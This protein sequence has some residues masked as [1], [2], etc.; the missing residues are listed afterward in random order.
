MTQQETAEFVSSLRKTFAEVEALPMPSIACV[1]GFALGGGAEL[2]LACDMRILDAS[3][4]FGFPETRL[5]IIPGAG[6]TQR[7]PRIVGSSKAKE[8]ILTGEAQRT[9]QAACC[10]NASLSPHM[11]AGSMLSFR[12]IYRCLLSRSAPEMWL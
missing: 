6:G 9:K 1:E 8:L 3:A 5:G 11:V 4:V 12:A 7:L 10:C 2:A